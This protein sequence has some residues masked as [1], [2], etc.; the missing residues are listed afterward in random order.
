MV[1]RRNVRFLIRVIRIIVK[2]LVATFV[3]IAFIG[4]VLVLVTIKCFLIQLS[5]SLLEKKQNAPHNYDENNQG[6]KNDD[7]SW[8]FFQIGINSNL[9]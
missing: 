2:Y 9:I 6:D 4:V 5:P 1:V 3:R 7:Q 8:E